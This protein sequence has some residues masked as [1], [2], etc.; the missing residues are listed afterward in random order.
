MPPTPYRLINILVILVVKH[1]LILGGRGAMARD[2]PR[3]AVYL[4]RMAA[5]RLSFANDD[6]STDNP[7]KISFSDDVVEGQ[8]VAASQ[9]T[10]S[11]S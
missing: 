5:Y 2:P 11:K 6:I 8:L 3:S 1:G 7:E 4:S 9:P 10:F